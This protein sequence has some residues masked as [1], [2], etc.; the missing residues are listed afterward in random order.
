MKALH[1]SSRKKIIYK[2]KNYEYSST[3]NY[4]KNTTSLPRKKK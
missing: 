4:F 2:C 3:K 1:N